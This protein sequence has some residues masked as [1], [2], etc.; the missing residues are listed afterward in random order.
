MMWHT[1]P[2]IGKKVKSTVQKMC[3]TFFNPHTV[4]KWKMVLDKSLTQGFLR[5]WLPNFFQ[6]IFNFFYLFLFFQNIDYL[7][8]WY[9]SFKFHQNIREKSSPTVWAIYL[10][11][12][13]PTHLTHSPK[14]Q[15]YPH[16]THPTEKV[17]RTNLRPNINFTELML[18]IK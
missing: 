7:I 15:T 13:W 9:N 4:G 6:K 3:H 11:I 8:P 1:D 2:E 10:T 18:Y 16:P 12:K 14:H 17:S 5:K